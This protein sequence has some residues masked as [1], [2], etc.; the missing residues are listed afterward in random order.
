MRKQYGT[1]AL[2]E[3]KCAYAKKN[4]F[5]LEVNTAIDHSRKYHKIP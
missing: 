5:S 1:Q 2:K 3:V 4:D